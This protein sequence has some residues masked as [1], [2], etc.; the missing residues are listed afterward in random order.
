MDTINANCQEDLE[1]LS[2]NSFENMEGKNVHNK[3]SEA[4][5]E[6]K[7]EDNKQIPIRLWLCS[8]YTKLTG[9]EA[10]KCNYCIS[11]F[12]INIKDYGKF[13]RHLVEKHPNKL[14]KNEKKEKK[15]G[16]FWDYFIPNNNMTAICKFCHIICKYH[17]DSNA[18]LITHLKK[19]HRITISARTHGDRDDLNDTNMDTKINANHL[20]DSERLSSNSF[21]NTEITNVHNR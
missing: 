14:T 20:E 11:K 13:H 6:Q 10:A 15:F 4:T 16:W 8:H 2:S 17:K 1:S 7:T 5:F 9:E 18:N 19:C 3:K 12:S 21:E